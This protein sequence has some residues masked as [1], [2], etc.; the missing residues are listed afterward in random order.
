MR[1]KR[2]I[3]NGFKIKERVA[4]ASGRVDSTVVH[5]MSK[6]LHE[7]VCVKGSDMLSQQSGGGG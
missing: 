2:G 3:R 1:G 5:G 7:Y 4:N 6:F